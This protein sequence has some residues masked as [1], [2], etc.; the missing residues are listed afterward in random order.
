[1]HESFLIFYVFG[2]LKLDVSVSCHLFKT[3]YY[4]IWKEKKKKKPKRR[5]EQVCDAFE[6]KAMI[7]FHFPT[8]SNMKESFIN[9]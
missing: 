2:V 4:D 8:Y 9:E 3:S 6:W 5:V 1:M 7:N